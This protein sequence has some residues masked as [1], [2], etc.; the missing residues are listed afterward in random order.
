MTTPISQGKIGYEMNIK[1]E[2]LS[3]NSPQIRDKVMLSKQAIAVI[4][5]CLA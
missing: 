5:Y 4:N 1:F 3:M 2:K